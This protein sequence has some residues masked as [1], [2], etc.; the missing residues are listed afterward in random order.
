MAVIRLSDGTLFVWSPI[1]LT[2]ALCAQVDA[3]GPVGHIVAPNTLHHVFVP[4]W[5]RA[6]P[7]A[8]V[9]AAPGLR[10]KRSDIAFDADL[11][12]VP[13]AAWADAVDQVTVPGNAITTEVVFFHRPSGT[14][15][16]VD[17]LQQFAPGWFSGWRSV[18]AKLDLMTVP[19]ATVPRKFRLAFR[20][21]RAARVAVGRILDW[22]TKKV[23]MAHGRPIDSD[24]QTFLRDAFRW[25]CKW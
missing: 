13:P 1:A 23:L 9:H 6:Y 20:D 11:G 5:Q 22:P 7:Q 8:Q 15:L 4:D 19:Q 3:L 12:D 2:D 18:V 16:F 24:G 21:R 17:L 14:V 10:A 25:L